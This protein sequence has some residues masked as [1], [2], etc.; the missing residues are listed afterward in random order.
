MLQYDSKLV[1]RTGKNVQ[2]QVHVH[3]IVRML[4]TAIALRNLPRA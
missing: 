1:L 3:V 4:V 2:V